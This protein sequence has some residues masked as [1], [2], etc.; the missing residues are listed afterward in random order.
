MLVTEFGIVTSVKARHQLNAHEPM[1]VTEFGI[2]ML[3][4]PEQSSNAFS[5]ILVTVLGIIVF[6]HPTT[7]A[8]FDFLMIALQLSRESNFRLPLSTVMLARPVHEPNTF[9]PIEETELGIVILVS[10]EQYLK[11]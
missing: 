10:L 5:P 2:V 11:A 3:V 9:S 7:S 6:L 8:L 4:R 1:L